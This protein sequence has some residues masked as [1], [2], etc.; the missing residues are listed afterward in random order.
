MRQC[1]VWGQTHTLWSGAP[2]LR[3]LFPARSPHSSGT[4]PDTISAPHLVSLSG[5]QTPA[6]PPQTGCH[7]WPNGNFVW[8]KNRKTILKWQQIKTNRLREK[9]QRNIYSTEI[10]LFRPKTTE[11][12]NVTKADHNC[13]YSDDERLWLERCQKGTQIP[14]N[15]SQWDFKVVAW[16]TELQI[17]SDTPVQF[18]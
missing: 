10:H 7:L 18:Y 9:T 13:A 16:F 12:L 6:E 8:D 1:S 4:S 17:L 3:R 5:F 11:E 2:G 15:D 14:N